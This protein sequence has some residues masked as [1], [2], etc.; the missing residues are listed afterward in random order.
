MID[1]S[2]D[3]MYFAAAAQS[4]FAIAGDVYAD[5]SESL[6]QRLVSRNANG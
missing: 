2:F 6:Q 4:F 3:Y 5:S 1:L